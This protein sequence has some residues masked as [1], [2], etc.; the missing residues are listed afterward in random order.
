VAAGLAWV[1]VAYG[2]FALPETLAPENRRAFSLRRASPLGALLQMRRYPVVFALL[3]VALL[4]Q[5]AHDA[6]PSTWTY[7]T[8]LKFGWSERQVGYSIGFIGLLIAIVQGGLIRVV[9]RRLGERRAVSFGLAMMAVGFFGFAFSRQGWGM[10]AFMV[11]FALCGV[12]MPALRSLMSREVPA[13]A[14]G[15]L[16]G[17]LTSLVSLTALAAPLAMTQLF[18]AF[19]GPRAPLYFPGASFFAA[20]ALAAGS[21]LVFRRACRAEVAA[22]AP[23][24]ADPGEGLG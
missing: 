14:Q 1:N 13:D 18:G 19:T 3:G 8:M 22:A 10:F 7:Y 5:V 16:Q 15:E 6:N 2:S 4:Y 12:A 23:A 20:G 21:L 11:P 17:A 24:L 9:I